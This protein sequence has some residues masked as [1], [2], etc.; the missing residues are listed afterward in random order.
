MASRINERIKTHEMR[1]KP[2]AYSVIC[3]WEYGAPTLSLSDSGETGKCVTRLCIHRSVGIM[4][5]EKVIMQ[6]LCRASQ[7][8]EGECRI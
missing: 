6:A 8:R 2:D 5:W 4:L 3:G 7:D 1:L